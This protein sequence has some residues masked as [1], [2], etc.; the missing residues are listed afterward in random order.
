MSHVAIAIPGVDR[1]GGAERQAMLLAKGLRR[2]GWRVSVVALS[3]CGG[4]AA[5]EL[6]ERG[7]AFVSL[8]MRKGLCGSAGMDSLPSMALARAARRGARAPAACRVAGTVVASG[9]SCPG[10]HRHAA[11]F[12]H[13]N[14]GAAGRLSLESL[15]AGPRNGGEPG[16]G[17]VSS[18]RRDGERRTPV[19]ARERD[20]S[21]RL[22]AGCSG[23]EPLRAGNLDWATSSC[24]WPLG[25]LE[26]VKD[27]PTLLNAFVR[28]PATARLLIVGTG[29][30]EAEL[31]QLCGAAR[32]GAARAVSRLR[33]EC[34]SA[35]CR[36]RMDSCCR[37]ATRA[38]RWC[39]WRQALADCPPSPPMSPARAR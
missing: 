4:A 18:G 2:R 27:Y 9:G 22:A 10:G 20:R 11:Q 35:G 14:D 1:I 25:R 23:R 8:E 33:A 34:A 16:H 12:A 28:A 38:C 13:R 36:P 19:R 31:V 30:L 17:G 15:A 6:R 21:G 5:K 39:C 3:G 7:V 29:P 37:R 26:P 32:P 24:G